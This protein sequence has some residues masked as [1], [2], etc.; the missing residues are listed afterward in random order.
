MRAVHSD[1]ALAG[2]GGYGYGTTSRG[3]KRVGYQAGQHHGQMVVK[4]IAMMIT[5]PDNRGL[6]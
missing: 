3:A 1:E 2:R 5:K 6:P 4:H